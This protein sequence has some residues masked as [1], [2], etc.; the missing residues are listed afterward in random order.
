VEGLS[1]ETSPTLRM[2]FQSE[3]V[4]CDGGRCVLGARDFAGNLDPVS[5]LRIE[6]PQGRRFVSSDSPPDRVESDIMTWENADRVP[7]VTFEEKKGEGQEGERTN[8]LL[9]G[10]ALLTLAALA[11][12]KRKN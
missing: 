8:L 7:G 11:V 6:L 9:A 1:I 3:L 4:S 5:I 2:G 12:S 10:A